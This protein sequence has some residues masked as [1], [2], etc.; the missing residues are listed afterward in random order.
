MTC[1]ASCWSRATIL[2]GVL[3][4][5]ATVSV[6]SAK[7]EIQVTEDAPIVVDISASQLTLI[8]LP[9]PVV[10]NG[11]ITV[12]PTLE[13]RANGKNV[14]IDPKGV[15]QP[16]DLAVLTEHQSYVFQ[17][18]PK[19]I[20]AEIIVVQDQRV[21]SGSGRPE[22]D[23]VKR[24][25]SYV[26]ANVELLRQ[27]SQGMLPK[28]CVSH[29]ITEK[30]YPKWLEIEILEGVEYRCPVYTVVQY[31]LYNNKDRAVSLRQTE[32]FTGNELSIGVSRQV[33]KPTDDGVVLIVSYTPPSAIETRKTT[34]ADPDPWRGPR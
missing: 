28:S 1:G 4:L 27:V 17:L 33:L 25:D 5:C 14:A 12:S 32:F 2:C 19:Q 16:A 29:V 18:R 31:R 7:Q 23:P 10:Q 3:S 8:K 34:S 11:L 9:S 24:S 20:P 22:A 13:I 15:Q 21:P 6:A 30:A 26:D